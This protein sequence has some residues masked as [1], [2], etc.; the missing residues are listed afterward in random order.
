MVKSVVW[1]YCHAY[2]LRLKLN[3]ISVQHIVIKAR[4]TLAW[5]LHNLL[6]EMVFLSLLQRPEQAFRL[7]LYRFN[8]WWVPPKFMI[9][10]RT[11]SDTFLKRSDIF[12]LKPHTLSPD[13]EYLKNKTLVLWKKESC[14]NMRPWSVMCG[15]LWLTCNRHSFTNYLPFTFPAWFQMLPW[16]F[17]VCDVSQLCVFS[18]PGAEQ[19]HWVFHVVLWWWNCTANREFSINRSLEDTFDTDQSAKALYWLQTNF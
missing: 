15:L 1:N 9:G 10:S 17:K 3:R 4:H 14:M 7:F 12:S 8:G 6:Q 5:F 16:D 11:K 13:W 18:P 19:M 2:D